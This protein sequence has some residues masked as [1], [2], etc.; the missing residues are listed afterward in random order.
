MKARVT[1]G[2]S[3]LKLGKNTHNLATVQMMDDPPVISALSVTTPSLVTELSTSNL[4]IELIIS[5]NATFGSKNLTASHHGLKSRK[6][7]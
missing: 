1:T 6:K 2:A 7:N 5:C 3:R 4:H